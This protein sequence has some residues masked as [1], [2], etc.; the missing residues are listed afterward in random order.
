MESFPGKRATLKRGC[1]VMCSRGGGSW[2]GVDVGLVVSSL[3][4]SGISVF[5]IQEISKNVWVGFFSV[6]D[7]KL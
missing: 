4:L 7:I 5:P 3:V 2:V 1:I 6:F